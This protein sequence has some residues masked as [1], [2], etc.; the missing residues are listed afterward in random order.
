MSS[1]QSRLGDVGHG[2]CPAHK[3]PESYMTVFVTGADTV[4]TNDITSAIIGTV[5]V[6]TCGHMTVALTGSNT[7]RAQNEPM[8]RVEDVGM[9]YGMY[10]T[11][12][13]SSDTFVG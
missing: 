10:T 1:E 9:N 4:K 8:H 13:G 5:G 3:H 11:L 6:S 12:T 7:V 2:V